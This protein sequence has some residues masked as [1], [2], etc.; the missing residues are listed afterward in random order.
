M[1]Q[2]KN[3]AK[4]H[5]ALLLPASEGM[6]PHGLVLAETSHDWVTWQVYWNGDTIGDPDGQ[7]HELWDAEHGHYFQ[8]SMH[9]SQGDPQE[10]A[11][12]AFGLRLRYLLGDSALR[13]VAEKT[14]LYR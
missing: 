10:L 2:V 12:F 4:V 14:G 13:G 6:K 3:G 9:L 5:A 1:I 7:T 8:K 11:K